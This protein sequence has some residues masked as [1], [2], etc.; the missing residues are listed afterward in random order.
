MSSPRRNHRN[1][2]RKDKRI[3]IRAEWWHKGRAVVVVEVTR[4][5][6][7]ITVRVPFWRVGEAEREAAAFWLREYLPRLSHDERY[8][9]LWAP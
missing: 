6:P 1:R 9:M 2:E 3:L 4:V 5:G 7:V 8:A